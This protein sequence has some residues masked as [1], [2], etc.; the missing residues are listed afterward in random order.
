LGSGKK[1][2]SSNQDPDAKDWL[3]GLRIDWRILAAIAIVVAVVVVLAA[4]TYS[5]TC[6]DYW[7]QYYGWIQ[8]CR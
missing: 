1:F 6:S 4:L 2:P 8:D 7:D 3:A 5:P